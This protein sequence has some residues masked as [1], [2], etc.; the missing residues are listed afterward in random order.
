[1]LTRQLKMAGID[2]EIF[3]SICE[4][5]LDNEGQAPFVDDLVG[6]YNTNHGMPNGEQ[7]SVSKGTI[8]RSI[9]RLGQMGLLLIRRTC[10]SN[11]RSAGAM[12]VR[13]SRFYIDIGPSVARETIREFH[14]ELSRERN[15]PK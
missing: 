14:E 8:N 6:I 1:M 7:M 3:G 13:G 15:T 9:S 12:S 5:M 4:F 2:E 11:I 10:K